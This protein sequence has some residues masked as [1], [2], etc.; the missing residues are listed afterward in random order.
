MK[1]NISRQHIYLLSVSLFLLFVVLLFA[2]LVLIP[3]GKSYR[4]QRTELK[5]ENKELRNYQNFHDET[6]ETLQKLRSDNRH[7]IEA[8]AASF[9]AQRFQK[10]HQTYFTSFDV[11]KIDSLKDEEDFA[12]YEVN[13]TSKI[14]SP[15][16]FYDF[17][18]AVNKSDWIIDIN[19][20][21]DFKR[22]GELI[23]SSF[24]MKVYCNKR[25][26]NTTASESVKK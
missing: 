1:I 8:F 10:Q 18:D 3:E 16:S 6:L 17:L 2:F 7:I 21:I 19:F 24:T 12:T 4:V 23:K 13:T 15:T 11:V 20:P 26:T 22:E 25:D 5:K 9:D 14:S